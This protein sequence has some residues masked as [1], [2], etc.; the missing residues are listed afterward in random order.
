MI[1]TATLAVL[2]AILLAG[3]GEEKPRAEPRRD[4]PPI[5]APAKP[6]CPHLYGTMA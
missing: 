2:L 5:E 6:G 4:C 3:C 1:R